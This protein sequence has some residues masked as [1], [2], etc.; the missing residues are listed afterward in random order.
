MSTEHSVMASNYAIDGNEVAFI[1][2]M[3]TEIYPNTS[4]S[5]VSDTYDYWN[6]VENII[7]SLKGE[8]LKH[9]GTLLIR[10]D[11]GDQFEVVT[12]T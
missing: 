7:P 3:L 10:P 11:S 2:R 5:M 6:L 1:K 8:V 9:N 4:F 12:K